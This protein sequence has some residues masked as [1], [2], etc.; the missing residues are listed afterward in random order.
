MNSSPLWI[1][2]WN[3]A[4]LSVLI[5]NLSVKPLKGPDWPELITWYSQV[6]TIILMKCK[7]K[8]NDKDIPCQLLCFSSEKSNFSA[9]AIAMSLLSQFS[10][11]R[12]PKASDLDWLVSEKDAPQ[13]VSSHSVS[14]SAPICTPSVWLSV[15]ICLP[16]TSGKVLPYLAIDIIIIL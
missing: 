10:E 14:V 5:L 6:L 9:E 4:C 8:D 11:K 2:K 3:D 1:S 7:Q 13:A 15:W 16:T 12:L